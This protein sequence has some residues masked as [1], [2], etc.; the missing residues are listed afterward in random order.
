MYTKDGIK[1]FNLDHI[2]DC[3]QCFRFD[4]T[5]DGGFDGVALGRYVRFCTNLDAVS[6]FGTG[7]RTG[8]MQS[9]GRRNQKSD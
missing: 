1:D 8:E 4:P 3:G 6:G 5:E 9:A 2:F 7:L